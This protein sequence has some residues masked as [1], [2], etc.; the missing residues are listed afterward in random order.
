MEIIHPRFLP[1]TKTKGLFIVYKL[2]MRTKYQLESKIKA[3]KL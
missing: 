2:G 3:R 1:L